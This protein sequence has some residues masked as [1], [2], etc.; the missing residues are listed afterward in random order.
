[1][2]AQEFHQHTP[3]H[4]SNVVCVNREHY[5]AAEF[6]KMTWAGEGLLGKAM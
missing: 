1:M 6:E 2:S 4:R 3:S 5:M